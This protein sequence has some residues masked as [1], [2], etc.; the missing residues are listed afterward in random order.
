MLHPNIRRV[1]AAV[2]VADV[3]LLS[4]AIFIGCEDLP[5]DPETQGAV[6][7]GVGGAVAGGAIAGEDD[8]LLGV[9]IGGALGAAGGYLI[10][11]N[12]DKILG[13]EDEDAR[14]AVEKAQNDP[15][16]ASEARD[17]A[18]ADINRD[19][20]VTLDEV[21]AMEEAGLTDDE[22]IERL[23]DT[24]QIFELTASQEQRLLDAGVSRYVVDEMRRINQD[25]RDDVINALNAENREVI[26]R[27]RDDR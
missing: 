4:P 2:C 12:K 15:A 21:M 20:F 23:E 13:D 5:G 10:G 18:T 9:L 6:I 25:E 27:D 24:G 1:A 11:A 26:G 8:R 19:G 14:R 22:M 7:G 3:L 16:T 17:A